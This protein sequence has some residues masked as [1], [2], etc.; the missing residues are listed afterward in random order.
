MPKA[1]KNDLATLVRV[2]RKQLQRAE[3]LGQSLDARRQEELDTLGEAGVKRPWFPDEEWRKDFKNVNETLAQ[4]GQSLIRGIEGNKKNL[5]SVPTEQLEAQFKSE[6]LRAAGS[7]TPEEW[8]VLD[9]VRMQSALGIP[10]PT[11]GKKS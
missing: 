1:L 5:G 11:K 7:F 4:A 10:A 6:L 8:A 2:S 3:A 9:K